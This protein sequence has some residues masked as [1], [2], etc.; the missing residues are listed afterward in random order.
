MSDSP[1]SREPGAD[2]VV[3]VAGRL[4]SLLATGSSAADAAGDVVVTAT[5]TGPGL[6]ILLAECAATGPELAAELLAFVER[7][8]DHPTSAGMEPTGVIVAPEA[9]PPD[10]VAAALAAMGELHRPHSA[11]VVPLGAGQAARLARSDADLWHFVDEAAE[12]VGI[13]TERPASDRANAAD[14]LLAELD[15]LVGRFA[16]PAADGAYTAPVHHD[17]GMPARQR[18]VLPEVPRT[19]LR[20]YLAA[21]GGNGL[22]IARLVEPEAIMDELEAAGLRG[23]GGAGFP[24]HIKWRTVAENCSPTEP[25]T[26]VVNAA[27]G[28][29]GTFKDRAILRA[30]PFQV[31][32]GALIAA[33]TIGADRVV[34][35]LKSTFTTELAVLRSAL[36]E[37]VA[38]GWTDG[39]DVTVFEGPSEYL[40]GEETALLETLDGRHPFPRLAPPYRRGVDE[41]SYFGHHETSSS[42]DVEMAAPGGSSDAPPAMV[43]NVETLANV[44]RIVSR[45]ARW[46]RAAGHRAVA[47]HRG[48]HDQRRRGLRRGGGAPDGHDRARRH[49]APRRRCPPRSDDRGGRARRV[50]ADA[51]GDALDTP[52]SFEAMQAAGSGLGSAGLRVVDDATDPVALA[53]GMSRFLAVE[54][55]GQCTPCKQDGLTVADAL[56][57]LCRDEASEADLETIRTRLDTMPTGARC[58]LPT[59][60]QAAVSSLLDA[61]PASVQAHLAR[62]VGVADPV[63]VAEAVDLV[64]GAL[65]VDE[66][67]ADKQPDWSHDPVWSG[68]AP[69]ERFGAPPGVD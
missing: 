62:E 35:A 67:Q 44:P 28:E 42:A 53:A 48:V 45:G 11:L 15:E 51:P 31:I 16:D 21:R 13:A 26:V 17:T 30:N 52:L 57:R 49:R 9:P 55:C 2:D 5:P 22:A 32:E 3:E 29:P 50:R 20:S 18:R 61:F 1:A 34:F 10:A 64:E 19:T 7:V 68:Q 38:A 8:R 54:S 47:R 40:Y 43:G 69:A 65:R 39:I 25:A 56:A 36:D 23:R 33:V 6:E 66:T 37:V 4:R 12:L 41:V 14:A 60:H 59:Q 58:S 27:E 63:L 46:F 24:T